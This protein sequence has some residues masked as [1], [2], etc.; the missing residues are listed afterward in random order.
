MILFLLT[1]IAWTGQ[2]NILWITSE[3]NGPH[4]GCYGYEQARTPNLDALAER[5]IRFENAW[6]NAPVCAPARTTLITGCYASSLGA[7]HM[8]SRVL[9]PEG[10]SLFPQLLRQ[11]GYY[12]SNRSKTDYNLLGYSQVWDQSNKQAH[13][14]GRKPG[15]PFFAVFNFTTTHESSTRRRPHDVVQDPATVQLPGWLPD[16]PEVREGWAQYY[17][18]MAVMD[19]QVGKVLKQ[20][21]EDGLADDTIVFYFG[22]H[23]PGFP[24][25]KRWPGNSGL[26]VPLI[27]YFPPKFQ[28]LAPQGYLGAGGSKDQAA[29]TAGRRSGEL[30][31]FVD[32]APTVLSLAGVE[33]PE[34]FQGRAFAGSARGEEPAFLY[35]FR[36]RMDERYDLC[37]SVRD[38]DYVYIR[39][40]FP[41]LPHGQHLSYL[42]QTPATQAWWQ[43]FEQGELSPE[44]RQY[45]LPRAKEELYD[46][47]NDPAEL[48]NLA[49]D[50]EHQEVLQRMRAA[51]REHMK[52]I[53]DLGLIPEA[54]MHRMAAGQAPRSL[55][56]PGRLMFWNSWLKAAEGS[57]VETQDQTHPVLRFWS[58]H[59]L[60]EKNAPLDI[61]T[62]N[63]MQVL[64]DDGQHAYAVAAA[65]LLATSSLD[66]HAASV[67]NQKATRK[68]GRQRLLQFAE[69][70][71]DE[72]FRAVAAWNAMQR[73]SGWTS[74]ELKQ[75]RNL[76][77]EVDGLAKVLG[78]Y[79][80]RLQE[81]FL[82][83]HG[84]QKNG[85]NN[86]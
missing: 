13:W 69:P 56:M 85:G 82:E 21:E 38:Q 3:D 70:T 71:K 76:P 26:R 6:S 10:Y 57:L 60:L 66:A 37:R 17:D 83:T 49:A 53:K 19:G 9:L 30:V 42:F 72:F 40:Y 68:A 74:D 23:G 20:L 79:L 52:R 48:Q 15:Q 61:G 86:E 77:T 63:L 35:G 46:L 33:I 5:G 45:W 47:G 16:L 32:L 27:A 31:S 25:A 4:L 11:A 54:D 28:H 59:Y 67:E 39:N 29:P 41:R 22:D 51:N 12:C 62:L 65:E 8:R 84:A 44:H 78:N 14:R 36:D 64:V 58:I 55:A 1:W 2:P 34:Y 80:P 18:Q 7:Q 75:V 24:R 50:P 73:T 81:H 43:A